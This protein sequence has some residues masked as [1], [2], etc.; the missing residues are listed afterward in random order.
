MKHSNGNKNK[1]ILTYPA[2]WWKNMWREAL[3]SGNGKIGASVYGGIKDETI[4][5]NHG[6][7]WHLGRKDH[8]PMSAIHSKKHGSSCP[9]RSIQKRVGI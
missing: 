2:S 5:M 9:I 1:L 4:L 3:P 7:L 8:V 6:D